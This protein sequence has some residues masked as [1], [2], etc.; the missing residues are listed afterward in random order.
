M[1]AL[2]WVRF[3]AT[4]VRGRE[5]RRLEATRCGNSGMAP[6]A[7]SLLYCL[8]RPEIYRRTQPGEG[9]KYRS[10]ACVRFGATGAFA[11]RGGAAAGGVGCQLRFI[12]KRSHERR[13]EH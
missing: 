1:G 7:D 4:M 8:K 10:S 6:E 3:G 5:M 2:K 11:V 12:G 9:R 13:T